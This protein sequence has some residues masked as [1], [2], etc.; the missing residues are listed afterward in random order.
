MYTK[1]VKPRIDS[2]E[3]YSEWHP[4]PLPELKSSEKFLVALLSEQ[5]EVL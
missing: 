1:I 4:E 3:D 2:D 5:E